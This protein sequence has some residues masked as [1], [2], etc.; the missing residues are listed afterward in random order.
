MVTKVSRVAKP[1]LPLKGYADDTYFKLYMADVGLM[2]AATN[3]DASVLLEGQLR[4]SLRGYKEQEWLT[5]VPLYAIEAYL[6]NG[7][8]E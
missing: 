2:G 5:N 4:F 3:L 7:G 6:R 8:T 1:G